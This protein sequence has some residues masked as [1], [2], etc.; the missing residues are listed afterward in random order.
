MFHL[1]GTNEVGPLK[2]PSTV[3]LNGNNRANPYMVSMESQQTEDSERQLSEAPLEYNN[4]RTDSSLFDDRME[5]FRDGTNGDEDSDN[6]N[7]VF[8]G[9]NQQASP[10]EQT[11]DGYLNQT[12][13]E[14]DNEPSQTMVDYNNDGSNYDSNAAVQGLPTL[15]SL[16]ASRLRAENTLNSLGLRHSVGIP[17]YASLVK[18]LL[19]D[20]ALGVK[21]PL[22]LDP[23]ITSGTA[24]KGNTTKG[25]IN[26][27]N[28]DEEERTKE[29]DKKEKQEYKK[30]VQNAE[31]AANLA[32]AAKTLT[33]LVKKLTEHEAMINRKQ[34]E[35]QSRK[36]NNEGLFLCFYNF[37]FFFFFFFTLNFFVASASNRVQT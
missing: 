29:D 16:I 8:A 24:K 14:E 26:T 27:D 5:S 18:Q 25:Q 9:D 33:K 21:K 37:F 11:N 31:M 34:E 1:E 36:N 12:P 32:E 10:Y 13:P 23:G 2:E 3:F 35:L 7:V 19:K 17:N 30:M 4:F 22:K 28:A 15:S 6:G 20:K